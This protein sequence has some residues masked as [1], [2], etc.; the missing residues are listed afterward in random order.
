VREK[1][2]VATDYCIV[3]E[4]NGTYSASVDACQKLFLH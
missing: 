4:V 1:V 3:S 2:P